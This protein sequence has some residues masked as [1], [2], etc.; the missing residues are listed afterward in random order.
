MPQPVSLIIASPASAVVAAVCG[1]IFA[2]LDCSTR[3]VLAAPEQF[4]AHKHT[5]PIRTAC[6]SPDGTFFV[7]SGEDKTIKVWKQATG[8][9]SWALANERVAEKRMVEV[10][11]SRDNTTLVCADKHGDVWTFPLEPATPPSKKPGDG[12]SI[13]VGHVSMVTCAKLAAQDSLIVTGDRDEHVRVSRFPAGHIIETF[14]LG[15]TQ[16]VAHLTVVDNERLLASA[17]GDDFV[18]LWDYRTGQLLARG[19]LRAYVEPSHGTIAVRAVVHHGHHIAAVVEGTNAVIVF[20]WNP[21]TSTLDLARRVTTSANLGQVLSAAFDTTGRLWIGAMGGL[22][23]VDLKASGSATESVAVSFGDLQ[24]AESDL[25]LF[26]T[27]RKDFEWEKDG[28]DE[29]E[30]GSKRKKP[31]HK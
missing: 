11:V 8:P 6:F 16:F 23:V 3:K 9:S 24:V 30:A 21:A 1:P 18:A 28:E 27:L 14:C 17:G 26:D 31:K 22:G 4:D 19:D 25:Y 5:G 10:C 7:T 29:D 2:I 12:G 13:I 20:R 15:H